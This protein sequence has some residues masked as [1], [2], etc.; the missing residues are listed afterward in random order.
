MI[1]HSHT[2]GDFL[3]DSTEL[4]MLTEIFLQVLSTSPCRLPPHLHAASRT[5]ICLKSTF[6]SILSKTSWI[7]SP[8]SPD[9]S[10]LLSSACH[11][12][13]PLTHTGEFVRYAPRMQTQTWKTSA[14]SL[15]AVST[16]P[17]RWPE[18]W[19]WITDESIHDSCHDAGLQTG[20][21]I[22]WEFALEISDYIK[23]ATN[24]GREQK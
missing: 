24:N 19:R 10:I 21:Q 17:C 22:K 7:L 1:S 20:L 11:T 15:H 12:P 3:K 18:V 4:A 6:C 13:L 23:T 5:V 2:W 16:L 14:S 8:I 9:P